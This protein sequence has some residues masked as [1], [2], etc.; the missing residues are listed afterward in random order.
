MALRLRRVLRALPGGRPQPAQRANAAGR[1][2]EPTPQRY[3]DAIDPSPPLVRHLLSGIVGFVLGGLAVWGIGHVG[4][5]PKP[6]LAQQ[7]PVIATPE[8]P[9]AAQTHHVKH[10]RAARQRRAAD[11]PIP[12]WRF[13][14]RGGSVLRDEAKPSGDSLKKESKGAKVMLETLQADG[15]AKVTDGNIQGWMRAS[16][17][18]MDPPVQK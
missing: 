9:V 10:E 13:V 17:L 16:V 3:P 11:G 18:G 15:W 14:H 2:A 8:N 1:G 5:P 4:T 6:V 7:A 12:G